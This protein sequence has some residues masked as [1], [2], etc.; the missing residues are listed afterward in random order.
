MKTTTRIVPMSPAVRPSWIESAPSEAPTERSSMIRTGAGSAP[1][2]STTERVFV[3]DEGR[4][5]E[6]EEMSGERSARQRGIDSG[7]ACHAARGQVGVHALEHRPHLIGGP[8]QLEFE[9]RRLPDE[10]PCAF[11]VGESRKLNDD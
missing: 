5:P 11:A 4:A 7:G 1:A 9:Q 8:H 6:I 10:L 3:A 2:R